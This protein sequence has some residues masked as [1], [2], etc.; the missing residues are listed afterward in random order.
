MLGGGVLSKQ[1]STLD[2]MRD[3]VAILLLYGFQ[4]GSVSEL[5]GLSSWLGTFKFKSPDIV[6]LDFRAGWTFELA[7]LSSW[8]WLGFRAGWTFALARRY[9]CSKARY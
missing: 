5:A 3:S 9:R 8:R 1:C 7:G 6:Y 2:S 4:P